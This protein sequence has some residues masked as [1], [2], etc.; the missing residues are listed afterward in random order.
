MNNNTNLTSRDE[1]SLPWVIGTSK[2]SEQVLKATVSLS[3]LDKSA[4][5]QESHSLGQLCDLGTAEK[6]AKA[7]ELQFVIDEACSLIYSL[8]QHCKANSA[9]TIG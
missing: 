3:G 2:G 8:I 7:Q 4:Q 5:S 6:A 9:E 1:R